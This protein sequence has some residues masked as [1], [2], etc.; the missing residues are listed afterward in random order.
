MTDIRIAV[1]IPTR[2]R[3][4][5]AIEAIRCLRAQPGCG[6]SVFVSD[7]SSVEAEVRRLADFCAGLD[8]RKII[9]ERAP[10]NL[11][12]GASWDW[13]V[14]EA[15]ARTGATHATVHYDRKNLRPGEADSLFA[16]AA[17][18]P[19]SV[20]TYLTDSVAAEPPPLRL[21]QA[22]W[23]GKLYRLKT[24]RTL[25]VSARGDAF[26]LG[27]LLP[28]LS[29]CIVPRGVVDSIVERFG[30]LCVSTTADSCFAYRFCAL[31]DDYLHLDRPLSVLYGSHRSAAIGYLSGGGG[32]FADYRETWRGE[33]WLDAA[34]IPGL[35]LGYNML[36]HEYELVRRETG[37][38][39]LSPLDR[40][41]CLRDL[42]RG[43][44]W[45]R[46]PQEKARLRGLLEDHGWKDEGPPADPP[47]RSSLPRRLYRRLRQSARLL[48]ADRFHKMPRS[49]TGFRFRSDEEALR[50][51]V[52]YPSRPVASAAHLTIAEPLEVEPLTR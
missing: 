48:L 29:N 45:I 4:D 52:K 35:N 20:I 2:N 24:S 10:G 47:A 1:A 7:N 49:I 30:T 6:L 34:A 19:D 26:D 3:A 16:A 25:E 37:G 33:E 22:E 39:R 15:L 21:W 8:D 23:T 40:E 5:M 13:A 11:P 51:A 38:D 9:Y 36:F 28:I 42:G 43:L 12:Q 18:F 17:R 44:S 14:R 41:G 31:H 50:Y 27:Q 32:D 46:D